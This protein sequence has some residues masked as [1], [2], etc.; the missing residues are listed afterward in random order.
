ME[1]DAFTLEKMIPPSPKIL[2]TKLKR[3]LK[4]VVNEFYWS[5]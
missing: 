5:L 4:T 1:W 3:A 2:K